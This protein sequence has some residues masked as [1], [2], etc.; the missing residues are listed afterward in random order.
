MIQRRIEKKI[1]EIDFDQLIETDQISLNVI[2]N[3]FEKK[4][5]SADLNTIN[6]IEKKRIRRLNFKYANAAWTDFIEM[7]KSKFFVNHATFFAAFMTE[8]NRINM[9]QFYFNNL[10]DSSFNWRTM[11]KHFHINEFFE[12][13]KI[14]YSVLKI[15]KTWI[16]ID[17]SDSQVINFVSLKWIF[18][19][20][21]NENDYFSKY[22][23]RL[24]IRNDFQ[25]FDIQNVYAVTLTIKIFKFLMTLTIAFDFRIHQLNTVNVFFNAQNDD[26][27]YCFLSDDYRKSEK[28]MKIMRVLY[29]QKKS[30]LLWL[31]TLILK[32]IKFKLY[33][34]FEKSCF[35]INNDEIIFF[36]YVDDIVI[37]YRTDRANQMHNYIKR[38]KNV[39]EIKDFEEVKFFLKIK[40]IKN[41]NQNTVAIA[42]NV[43]M[44]K[45][46]KK[47]NIDVAIKT[48]FSLL[49]NDL[50]KYEGEIYFVRLH[51]YR[52][53]IESIFY[54]IV[55]IRSDI[56]KIAFKLSEFLINSD[57]NH[58]AAADQCIR[59]LHATKFLEIQ[60]SAST[61]ENQLSLQIEN[62]EFIVSRI[63]KAIADV[64][65]ANYSDR[66]SDENYT[67]RLFDDFIDWAIKKKIIV[68]IFI[69]EIKLLSLLHAKKEFLWWSNL[70]SKLK[71]NINHDFIIFNDNRQIIRLLISKISR[72]ETKLRHIN[73]AQCWLRQEI[74]KGRL[75]IEYIFTI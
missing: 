52:K 18:T 50:I 12:T 27:I 16:I 17:K 20:K 15:R 8:T 64:S 65:Y 44:K 54:S 34:I 41:F 62:E 25:E 33:Q 6:I 21:I 29:D 24:I 7:K 43:Y 1:S 57:S 74:E 2:E 45:L 53:K 10:S 58:F 26:L 3:K 48:S 14:E 22:K 71:F 66:K 67:F 61:F 51:I 75:M 9:N 19:Y 68:I 42:Q 40:I 56:A 36:Y 63:F 4:L 30:S 37:A 60:Y 11:L 35:F 31:K 5:L 70:F 13:A 46:I 59:Y 28:I 69:T 38:F 39:F 23:T 32:C 72:I 47:Y 55:I 49:S 73:I